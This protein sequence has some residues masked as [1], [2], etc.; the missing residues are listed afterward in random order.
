MKDFKCIVEIAES[1]AKIL[2]IL[3][4]GWWVYYKFI[5]QRENQPL[6]DFTVDII[7]HAKQKDYWIVE[8]VAYI[9]NKGK[10]QHRLYDFP[11]DLAGL[12][13]ENNVELT[14][15]FGNQV[16]FPNIIATGS[17]LPARSEYFFIEPGLKNKYS[18][19]TRV[20]V[21]TQVVLMH[22]S[23]MYLDGKHSHAAEVTRKVPID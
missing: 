1:I 11:F 6:I 20:P 13:I 18:F 7:F 10:V 2:G 3:I 15:K 14:Q 22:S 9:E 19:L 5:R 17:F 21:N 4:G 16:Y 23:F 8:L 12:N